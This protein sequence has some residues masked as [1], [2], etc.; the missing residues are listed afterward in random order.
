M[1]SELNVRLLLKAVDRVSAPVRGISRAFGGMARRIVTTARRASRAVD[2]IARAARR[3]GGIGRRLFLRLTAPLAAAG[4]AI[5]KTG[6]DFSETLAQI[7]GLVGVSRGQIDAWR[8][9]LLR[10]APAL[11][12]GPRELAK[13]LFFITSAGSRGQEAIDTLTA[14]AKA[15]AAGLGET[16]DIARAVTSA[17]NAYGAANLGAGKA[18]GILVATVREGTAAASSIA[19]VLGRVLPIAS[20]LGVGFDEVGASIAAMT[21]LGSNAEQSVTGLRGVLNAILKP[22]DEARRALK[23]FGL[24]SKGLK[25]QLREE[26]LL[27]VLQTLK[28]RFGGNERAM[29]AMFPDIEGL[30]AVFSLVG[31]NAAVTERIFASLASA[32]KGDLGKAFAVA[33][34]EPNF[35]FR[36]SLAAIESLLIRLSEV[37]LPAVVAVVDKITSAA[38]RLAAA[39]NALD[40]GAKEVVI[41]ATAAVAAIAPV[42]VA[43]GVLGFAIKGLAVGWGVIAAAAVA[44][45][46]ALTG[47]VIAAMGVITA[48]IAANPIAAAALAIAA[49]ATLIITNWE[50]ISD[51]FDKLWRGIKNAFADGVAFVKGKIKLLTDLLPSFTDMLPSFLRSR[52][53]FTAPDRFATEAGRVSGRGGAAPAGLGSPRGVPAQRTQVEGRVVLEI[54]AP[55]GVRVREIAP[56]SG[57]IEVNLGR[58][59]PGF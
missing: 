30:A 15:S 47:P 22:A 29:S 14:S 13:A 56:S 45:G 52:L 18:T 38:E 16:A 17:V 11:G 35:K 40:P 23:F 36:R 51:F 55:E 4:I 19:G 53:G 46:T 31:K 6:G 7:E 21:R 24:S 41:W 5:V 37:V 20:Q 1:A 34:R 26:G 58:V 44:F 54:D 2:G 25:R 48:A 10:L 59:M 33:A 57:D 8:G 49:A 50:P 32:T 12:K 27:A 42:L 28:D 39:F 3:A 9:D 43:V